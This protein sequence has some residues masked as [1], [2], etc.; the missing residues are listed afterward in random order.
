MFA[1]HLPSVGTSGSPKHRAG[2]WVELKGVV[3]SQGW[4]LE[5]MKPNQ[6]FLAHSVASDIW[7]LSELEWKEFWLPL[8]CKQA[9]IVK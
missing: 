4:S 8:Q 5:E 2:G 9:A 3:D 1:I 7:C 6:S